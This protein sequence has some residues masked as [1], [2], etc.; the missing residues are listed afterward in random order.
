[1]AMSLIWPTEEIREQ[2][3]QDFINEKL[4]VIAAWMLELD[5]IEAAL[6][7]LGLVDLGALAA[8][9]EIFENKVGEV[10]ARLEALT[11]SIQT[12]ISEKPVTPEEEALN[13]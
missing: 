2:E 10:L 13:L 4:N 7:T 11:T 6:P 12:S 1:M 8:I 9:G 5:E 3:T